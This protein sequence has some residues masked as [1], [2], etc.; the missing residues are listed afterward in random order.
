[1]GAAVFWARV[2][3]DWSDPREELVRAA[4]APPA[5]RAGRPPRPGLVLVS[6]NVLTCHPADTERARALG[7][8]FSGRSLELQRA[9][10][11]VG[12][13]AFPPAPRSSRPGRPA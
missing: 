3:D 8:C 5:G 4:A 10:H 9:F 12:A 2:R 7:L 11:D 1:M 6:A 13:E